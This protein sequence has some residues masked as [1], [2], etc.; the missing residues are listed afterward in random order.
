MKKNSNLGAAIQ[1]TKIEKLFTID[2]AR[3]H[4]KKLIRKWAAETAKKVNPYLT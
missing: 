1:Q 3:V 4:I 2:E